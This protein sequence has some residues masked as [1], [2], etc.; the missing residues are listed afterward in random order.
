MGI[1]GLMAVV[2]D[3]GRTWREEGCKRHGYMIKKD[4]ERGR[5]CHEWTR[6][7]RMK[8]KLVL[9]QMPIVL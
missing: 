5:K 8:T 2:R 4:L 3:M 1:C 7:E 6:K 9:L